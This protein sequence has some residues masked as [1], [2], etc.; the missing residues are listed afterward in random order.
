MDLGWGDLKYKYWWCNH[1]N[2]LENHI[3]FPKN[4]LPSYCMAL[5]EGNK[6]RIRDRL[7]YRML[8]PALQQLKKI[9]QLRSK[10]LEKTKN[11]TLYDCMEPLSFDNLDRIDLFQ[12]GYNDLKVILNDFIYKTEE[13]FTDV[14]VYKSNSEDYYLL[15]G[16]QNCNQL[17]FNK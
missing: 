12:G 10:P 9:F 3:L 2:Y 14:E 13:H 4:S 11:Y 6:S 15:K 16:K 5:W 1:I 8:N 17:V 7:Q